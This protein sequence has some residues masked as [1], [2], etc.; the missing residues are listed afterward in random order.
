MDPYNN[1]TLISIKLII[2]DAGKFKQWKFRIQQYLQHEYYALWE[3]IMF[4]NSYKAPPDGTAKDK[5]PAGEVSSST[6]KK[7]RT[8]AITA[9]DIQKR[10]NDVK[11]RTT[12]LLALPDE[13]QLLDELDIMSLDDVYNHLKVYEPEMD[14]KWNLALLSMSADRFWK[15]TGKKITIQGSD[16]AS[17]EKSKVECFYCHKMGHFG[18]ECI[19]LRSQDKRK[20]ESYKKDFKVEEPASKAMVSID[21]YEPFNGG[22]VSLGHGRGKITGN[23]SIKNGKSHL[24]FKTMNK[25]VWRNLVKGFPSKSFE[26]DHSCVACLK[27]KHHKASCKSKLVNFVSKPDSP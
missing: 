16:V 7:G 1:S 11:A 2:H 27:G 10:K 26:N 6:K 5:G 20:R 25:L 14:I 4:G 15:K 19:S 21:E 13:H 8:V 18:R 3:V 12:L 23:G 9:E 22:Y 17:F 24:N